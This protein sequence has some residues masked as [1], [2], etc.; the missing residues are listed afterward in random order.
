ME[1][2]DGPNERMT[3][4]DSGGLA[5]KTLEN[6]V[7]IDDKLDFFCQHRLKRERGFGHPY[8]WIKAIIILM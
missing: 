4:L 3:S 5:E 2:E 6:R 7:R 8:S 1:Q